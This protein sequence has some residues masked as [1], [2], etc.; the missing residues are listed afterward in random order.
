MENNSSATVNFLM[1]QPQGNDDAE[2]N[3]RP[4]L[5]CSDAKFKKKVNMKKQ[6][7]ESFKLLTDLNLRNEKLL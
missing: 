3:P 4:S 1:P 5:Q 6:K 2:R 7:K